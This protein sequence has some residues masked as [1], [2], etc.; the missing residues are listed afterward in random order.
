[1]YAL[2]QIKNIGSLVMSSDI[3]VPQRYIH[4]CLAGTEKYRTIAKWLKSKT[5]L[6]IQMLKAAEKYRNITF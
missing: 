6:E 1:M 2:L 5:S 4:I 3:K